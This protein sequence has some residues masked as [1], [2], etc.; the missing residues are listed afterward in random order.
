MNRCRCVPMWGLSVWASG[1][2][3]C[4]AATCQVAEPPATEKVKENHTIPPARKW[5]DATGQYSVTATLIDFR[6]GQ[7]EL[8]TEDGR[9]VRVPIARLSD[10]DRGYLA[11]WKRPLRVPTR[12]AADTPGLGH[13]RPKT[14]SCHFQVFGLY[15]KEVGRANA[16]LGPQF[17]FTV[18]GDCHECW[19]KILAEEGC[20]ALHYHLSTCRT[21]E[22]KDDVNRRDP[23]WFQKVP[24]EISTYREFPLDTDLAPIAV[25]VA[26]AKTPH[27]SA[28]PFFAV[29]FATLKA[30]QAT[31]IEKTLAGLPG[32][33][34]KKSRIDV[35][36]GRIH[37][38]ISG[39]QAIRMTDLVVAFQ[40][41]GIP[42][43]TSPDP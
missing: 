2:V 41:V 23:R 14:G 35:Q 12:G 18:Y 3:A 34:A 1:L 11:Q 40:S 38:R 37:V 7:V 33:D 36:G 26:S 13:V 29:L 25:A 43:T 16:N 20:C 24:W 30:N 21:G 19:E 6:D 31:V 27:R 4:V 39:Q 10:A 42:V 28:R 5:T 22:F 15:H 9:V 32:V 8:K 17:A